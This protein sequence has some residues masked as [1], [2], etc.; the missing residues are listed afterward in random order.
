MDLTTLEDQEL[1]QQ[2][3]KGKEEALAALYDRYAGLIFAVGLRTFQDRLSAD[4]SMN[5]GRVSIVRPITS[6]FS[7]QQQ[8]GQK[9]P[10]PMPH[11]CFLPPSPDESPA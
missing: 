4:T 5:I 2:I 1:L 8:T 10:M 9:T 7:H 11:H 3:V 6:P